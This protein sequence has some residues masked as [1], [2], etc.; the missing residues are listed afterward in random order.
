ML[1]TALGFQCTL[2][3]AV[4]AFHFQR[5]DFS[6]WIRDV[7]QD[8]TLARWVDRLRTADLSGEALRETL[9]EVLEQR[10][11]ALVHVSVENLV[12]SLAPRLRPVH[13]DVGV[14]EYLLRVR[15]PCRAVGN[16]DRRGNEDLVPVDREI[17]PE[18]LLDP[19]GDVNRTRGGIHPIEENGELVST[20]TGNC[21]AGTEEVLQPARDSHQQL[22][23]DKE[24]VVDRPVARA[25]GENRCGQ[26]RG[27]ERQLDAERVTDL[28]GQKLRTLSLMG[29]VVGEGIG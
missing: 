13:G 10:H 12:T 1:R 21:V 6:R 29:D 4:I 26:G 19:V 17:H 23:T 15:V 28:L 11:R 25:G 5:E 2:D 24:G 27:G 18:D 14:S 8:E 7:L 16:P 9:L 22:V 20:E 3:L